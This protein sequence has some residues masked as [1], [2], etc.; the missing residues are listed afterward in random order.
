MDELKEVCEE[1]GINVLIIDRA[2]KKSM[3]VFTDLSLLIIASNAT[4]NQ[5]TK[6]TSFL[7]TLHDYD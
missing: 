5:I 7:H 2:L 1:M 4:E 3:T 6:M